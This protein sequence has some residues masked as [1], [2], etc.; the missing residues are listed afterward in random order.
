MA[1]YVF[2]ELTK[3]LAVFSSPIMNRYG[4]TTGSIF[5]KGSEAAK[6]VQ[7]IEAQAYILSSMLLLSGNLSSK[8]AYPS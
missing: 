6:I 3:Q 5:F 2:L 4:N 1:Y 7:G 8:V